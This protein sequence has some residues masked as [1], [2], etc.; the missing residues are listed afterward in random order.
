MR[1]DCREISFSITLDP[2]RMI[3]NIPY[4]HRPISSYSKMIAAQGFAIEEFAEIFPDSE[5]Q[6]LYGSKWDAPR[7]LIVVAVPESQIVQPA[8]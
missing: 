3:S 6:S 2:N 7:Y 1:E 8:L 4:C 5:I